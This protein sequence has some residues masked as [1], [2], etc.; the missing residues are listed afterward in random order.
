M[1]AGWRDKRK[2]TKKLA[3]CSLQ[4]ARKQGLK[5]QNLY[6]LPLSFIP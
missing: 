1:A 3:V 2:K 6:D 5:I 4:L